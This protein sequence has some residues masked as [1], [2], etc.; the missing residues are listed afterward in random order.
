MEQGPTEPH[1]G[2][3]TFLLSITEWPSIRG[4]SLLRTSFPA[5]RR[6]HICTGHT[7]RTDDR[8]N[9]SHDALKCRTAPLPR[10]PGVY[11]GRA[12]VPSGPPA[13]RIYAVLSCALDCTRYKHDRGRP[14]HDSPA[15]TSEDHGSGYTLDTQL[16]SLGY[17]PTPTRKILNTSRCLLATQLPVCARRRLLTCKAP[18]NTFNGRSRSRLE[19]QKKTSSACNDVI[20][21]HPHVANVLPDALERTDCPVA[22]NRSCRG[23][24]PSLPPPPVRASRFRGSTLTLFCGQPDE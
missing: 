9:N 24:A 15:H 11:R 12:G 16:L 10:G 4:R 21:T 6:W 14:Q 5:R 13:P 7:A 17:A 18:A 8:W 1:A 23:T 20:P 3:S 22:G 19:K 2:R